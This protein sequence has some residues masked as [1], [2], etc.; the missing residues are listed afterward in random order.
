MQSFRWDGGQNTMYELVIGIQCA[1]ILILFAECWVIMTSWKGMLHSYLFLGCAATIVTNVGYLLELV[2]RTEESFFNALR[3]SYLG[4][5]WIVF[6]LFLFIAQ[7]VRVSIPRVLKAVL[8]VVNIAVYVMVFTTRYTELYYK[9]LF[10]FFN[11]KFPVLGHK[12]GIGHIWWDIVL[13]L[14]VACGLTL[15]I[16]SIVKERKLLAKKRLIMV[17]IAIAIQAIALI[18]QVFKYP[19]FTNYYD[20]TMVGYP[21]ANVFMLIAIFRYKLL[22]ND[23]LVKEYIID[24]LSEGIITVSKDNKISYYN[25]PALALMPEIKTDPQKVIETLVES[26]E[27]HEPLRINGNVYVPAPSELHDEER[28]VGTVY[29]LDDDTEHFKYMDDLREQTLIAENASKAKTSFLANMSHEIRTPI[30][31]VLGMDEMII[32]ESNQE[33]IRS[34]AV[35]IRNAG[36]TLLSLI[37]DILDFSKIEEGRM[38]IIPVQY[39]LSS[40]INDLLNMIRERALKKGLEL[41]VTTDKEVPHILYGDEIRIRQVALN[42]LTNAVKYTNKGKITFEVG[43]EKLSDR[44][45]ALKFRVKDTGIGMKEEDMDKLFTPFTRIEE[46]RNRSVEG[47][48]LGMSIVTQL[49]ALMDSKLDVKSTYGEGSEFSFA[50]TQDV[51]KWE[52]MGELA[53]RFSSVSES[54]EDYHELFQAPDA[55]ILVVDDTEVNL[56]VVK[57]LLKQTQVV[58]DT[59]TSGKEAITLV[60]NNRYDVVFIDHMMPDMDGIETLHR[61]KEECE[62]KGTFFVALTANAVSGSRE[63]YISEGFDDY[64]SKPIDGRRLEE[65]LKNYLPDSKIK[66]VIPSETDAESGKN[67]DDRE[68]GSSGN[69]GDSGKAVIPEWIKAIPE[70][71]INKGIEG[72]GSEESFLSVLEVFY[73][74]GAQKADEIERFYTEEDWENYTIKVHALKSSARIIGAAELSEEAR[75]LE[76]AGKA[77]ELE[78]IKRGTEGLLAGYRELCGKLSEFD[79]K[80]GDREK[81][82]EELRKDAFMTIAEVADSM[83][84]GLME[85][86]IKDLRGYS[87]SKEDET[88]VNEVEKKLFELDWEGII[89]TV[90]EQK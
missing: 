60:K 53:E 58:I 9:D 6:A 42:L 81:L 83:D 45:I 88:V 49:L 15:L 28:I 90:K 14:Y 21:I 3:L 18:L 1:S 11:G 40:L 50:I 77:R 41:E 68:E 70:I 17:S 73:R 62:T 65:M 29:V 57:N 32:R 10:F 51:V 80:E 85:Q 23:A 74:T 48:G 13:F 64:L 43:F 54:V 2:S 20:L 34:Y 59:V 31:A 22:D 67:G 52:P 16:V 72:C 37:N 24:E 47:T 19:S 4:K 38:E 36:R 79:E 46:K 12:D 44:Q 55:H 27:N 5:I 84:Y 76:E 39:E 71:D 56:V 8:A 86:L 89:E 75:D 82:S 66:A 61:I 63:R 33:S 7:L 35:D 78:N 30:N 87:L 25:K 69:S 26:V